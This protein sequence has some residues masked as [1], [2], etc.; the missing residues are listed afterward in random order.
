MVLI[1]SSFQSVQ[2]ILYDVCILN[3]DQ[4]NETTNLNSKG[5]RLT[6][7]VARRCSIKEAVI[8]KLTGKHLRLSLF[9]KKETP[10]HVFFFVNFAKFL[11]TASFIKYLQWL[12][13]D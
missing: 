2:T 5:Q 8:Q 6:G 10:A 7:A 1:T 9:D 13:L 3:C 12:L 4:N 11:R